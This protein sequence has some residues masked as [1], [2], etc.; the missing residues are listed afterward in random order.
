VTRLPPRIVVDGEDSARSR[1][2]LVVSALHLAAAGLRDVRIDV[3]N[4][5]D[6][7]VA[8]ALEV[9]VWETGLRI[10]PWPSSV[11]P[12]EVLREARLLVAVAVVGTEHL[13][14]PAAAAAGVPVIAAVQFPAPEAG[15]AT[16]GLLRAAHDPRALAGRLLRALGRADLAA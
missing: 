5:E 3:M 16:L 7:T 14:I 1:G 2:L 15:A 13:P 12:R 9:L 10:A 11:P 6:P 4:A 8:T